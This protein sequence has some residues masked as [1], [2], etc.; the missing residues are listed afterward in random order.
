M[1]KI[2]IAQNLLALSIN[3]SAFRPYAKYFA[4]TICYKSCFIQVS[5][6]YSVVILCCCLQLKEKRPFLSQSLRFHLRRAGYNTN[7]IFTWRNRDGFDSKEEIIRK[8][9]KTKK[10]KWLCCC[11]QCLFH[12]NDFQMLSQI[13]MQYEKI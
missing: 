9:V 5:L 11:I 4:D 10:I 3:S 13:K 6:F 8:L 7:S 12:I 1:S 2:Q